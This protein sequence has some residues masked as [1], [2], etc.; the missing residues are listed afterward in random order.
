MIKILVNASQ[1]TCAYRTIADHIT[2]YT[3]DDLAEAVGIPCGDGKT[4]GKT[5]YK[6]GFICN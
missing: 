2:A 4:I 3:I 1:R 5:V 6:I